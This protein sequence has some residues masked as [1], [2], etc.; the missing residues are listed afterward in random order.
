[1]PNL[2][3]IL[4]TDGEVVALIKPQFEAGK[5]KVGKHGIVKDP[6]VHESVLNDIVSFAIATGYSVTGL[7]F[8]PIKGGEGNIEFLIHLVNVADN[9]QL[10]AGV[11]AKA[12]LQAAYAQLNQK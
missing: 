7:D 2:K 6:V 1:M 4:Q 5:N 11:S 12:T 3:T 10:A 8:S 9:A